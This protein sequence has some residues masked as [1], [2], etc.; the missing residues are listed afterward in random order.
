M[1]RF[2]RFAVNNNNSKNIGRNVSDSNDPIDPKG[3]L[4]YLRNASVCTYTFYAEIILVW[5]SIMAEFVSRVTSIKPKSKGKYICDFAIFTN[6][7]SSTYIS[8]SQK[9]ILKNKR[10]IAIAMFRFENCYPVHRDPEIN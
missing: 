3:L 8:V 6:L 1:E 5:V 2:V 10:F 9:K 4:R 7:M